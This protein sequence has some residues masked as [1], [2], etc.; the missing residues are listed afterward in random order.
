MGELGEWIDSEWRWRM[1]WRRD[2]FEWESSLERDLTALLGHSEKECPGHPSV[3]EG[4]TGLVFG[5]LC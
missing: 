4:G 5:E 1:R 3:G 2:R